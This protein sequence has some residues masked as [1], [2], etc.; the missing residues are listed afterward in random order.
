MQTQRVG[1]G[2]LILP[3]SSLSSYDFKFQAQ[4]VAGAREFAAFFHIQDNGVDGGQF[5][6]DTGGSATRVTFVQESEPDRDPNV[7][8]KQIRIQQGHWYDVWVK[9]RG[10][11]IWCYLDDQE[12]FHCTDS[13]FKKGRVGFG[14]N[15]TVARFRNIS[16][17]TPEGDVLW[18]GLPDLPDE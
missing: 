7:M 1:G 17:A 18:K 9:V 15:E 4:V 10:P 2:R 5:Y 6:S 13:P 14:T 12:W 3:D 11:K 8:V 16:V